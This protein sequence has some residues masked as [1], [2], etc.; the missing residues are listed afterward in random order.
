MIETYTNPILAGFYPDPS[1]IR[2]QEDFFLVAS[3]FAYFPGIP[4]F[5][6]RD[7]VNWKLIGHVM[8]RPEQMDLTGFGVSRGIFAPSIH[9]HEGIFYVTCTL[10]DGKGNFIAAAKDPS[11]PWSMPV[12]LPEINGIDP[13]LFFDEDGSSYIVYNSVPPGN[14]SLY[15]GHRTIRLR[16]FDIKN[17]KVDGPETIIVNG[18]TDISRKPAW[19]EGPH[20]LKHDGS[21]FLVAAEG[22]TGYDHSVVAFRSENVTGPY[23]SYE[24]NPVL[25]QRKPDERSNPVTSTG[26]AQLV[27]TS[28]GNW[29]AVFLGCRPYDGDHYNTGRETFL[30]PVSWENGWPIMNPGKAQVEYH[31]PLPLP[32]VNRQRHTSVQRQF[33]VYR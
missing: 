5:H 13:S 4:V 2:V 20:I 27:E 18:G 25:R 28:S 24:K 19:I 6:S 15:D 31:Y 1:I 14:R 8:S 9:F 22:G 11:G 30:V 32:A 26:H 21:Y 10:V 17:L 33:F 16:S 3:T 12:W 29:H 23:I 7:L